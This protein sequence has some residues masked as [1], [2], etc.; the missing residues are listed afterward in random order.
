MS[1]GFGVYIHLPFCEKLCVYCDFFVS[2]IKRKAPE[3]VQAIVKEIQISNPY[4]KE[5]KLQTIYFGGGTPSIIET[6][7]VEMILKSMKS[8]FDF[9]DISEITLE[10]NPNDLT[11]EKL[12]GLINIGI[13]RLSIGI[14]SFNDMELKFLSRNHNGEKAMQAV[15]A[16]QKNGFSNL[17]LDL[18]FGIPGQTLESWE[19]SLRT[20]VSLEPTHISLYNL[21][22]EPRTALSKL[23]RFGQVKKADE[24]LEF[25]MFKF[26]NISLEKAGYTHY[27]ISNFSKPGFESKHNS[28]YWN[29]VSYLGLGPSAH[30]YDGITRWW[31]IANLDTYLENVISEDRISEKEKLNPKQKEIEFFLLSLRQKKGMD[32][33]LYSENFGFD[34]FNRFQ[35]PIENL[36]SFLEISNSCVRLNISG[37]FLYNKICEEFI[38]KIN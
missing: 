13:N 16:A 22:I 27:E 28:S 26:A 34:F 18:I 21:T 30:S 35:D 38:N 8:R 33:N 15:R 19:T 36:E 25:E 17:S 11:A 32:L 24:D 6:H 1:D 10:A 29:G 4:F 5:K 12:D 9:K 31:N 20:A 2:T 37:F 3:L 14:Q 23:I 7:E